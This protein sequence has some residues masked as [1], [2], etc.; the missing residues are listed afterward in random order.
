MYESTKSQGFV[1]PFYY[2]FPC[3][4]SGA[5]SYGN[6]LRK[7]LIDIGTK[8]SCNLEGLFTSVFKIKDT[9]KRM[10]FLNLL[11]RSR[12]KCWGTFR[13]FDDEAMLGN[14]ENVV[15]LVEHGYQGR[16]AVDYLKEFGANITEEQQRVLDY[17]LDHDEWKAMDGQEFSMGNYNGEFP[18]PF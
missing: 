9:S 15:W 10:R 17:L 5:V 8:F 16:Y 3:Q 12:I 14:Y 11:Y 2:H 7:N 18:I 4:L 13:E 1:I 6:V